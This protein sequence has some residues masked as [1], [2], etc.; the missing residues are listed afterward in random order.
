ME[1]GQATPFPGCLLSQ[2][3]QVEKTLLPSQAQ[4]KLAFP[5]FCVRHGWMVPSRF[6]YESPHS[7][8]MSDAWLLCAAFPALN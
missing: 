3:E 5:Y 6:A 7:G 4:A 8:T 1:G 2:L